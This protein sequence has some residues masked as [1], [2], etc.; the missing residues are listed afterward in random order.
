MNIDVKKGSNYEHLEHCQS[1]SQ[2]KFSLESHACVE[3]LL[4]AVIVS[5]Y[6]LVLYPYV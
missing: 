6:Q 3:A 5:L 2:K 4:L 1:D